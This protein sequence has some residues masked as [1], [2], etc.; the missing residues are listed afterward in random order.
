MAVVRVY[1]GVDEHRCRWDGLEYSRGK[2]GSCEHKHYNL[3]FDR[4]GDSTPENMAS[5]FNRV[6]SNKYPYDWCNNTMTLVFKCI[7]KG[8]E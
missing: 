6:Y 4:S 7:R 5:G 1:Q 8:W 2:R 3:Q